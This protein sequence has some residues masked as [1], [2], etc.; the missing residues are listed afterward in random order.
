MVWHWYKLKAWFQRW[1]Y[2]EHLVAHLDLHM[3]D[4]WRRENSYERR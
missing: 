1:W 2:P 4:E 3:S